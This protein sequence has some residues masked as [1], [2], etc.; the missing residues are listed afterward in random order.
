MNVLHFP[1]HINTMEQEELLDK[2]SGYTRGSP[3]PQ[4]NNRGYWNQQSY[5]RKLIKDR[6]I[7]KNRETK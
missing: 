6:E 5:L 3:L 1:N 4:V 7:H 2:I